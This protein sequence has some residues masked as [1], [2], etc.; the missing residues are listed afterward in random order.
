MAAIKGGAA[1]KFLNTTQKVTQN[2]S[3]RDPYAERYESSTSSSGSGSKGSSSGSA[4]T[5]SSSAMLQAYLAELERQRVQAANDAYNRNVS[6]LNDAYNQRSDLLKNNYNSTLQN[7]ATDYNA[8]KDS[9]NAD[10][11]KAAREAYIN[12]MLSR[13]N[14]AQNMAAQGLSGGASETTMAGL[15]NNY[16]NA[17]NEIQTTA[18]E[19]LGNLENLYTQNKNSALQAY[20]DQLAADALQKAQYMIQFENDRQNLLTQA[21]ESQLSQL[22][23]LDPTYLMSMSG[24]VSDQSAYTPTEQSSPS[25]A[26]KTVNTQQGNSAT[27]VMSSWYA[28][29]ARQLRSAGQSDAQI[30]QDLA[31]QG[32]ANSSILYILNQL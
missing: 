17:R 5:A 8:S 18:N 6:A 19:N 31:N 22:A 26:T 20:N 4:S 9:I 21:Y 29:R 3:Q 32:L 12:S 23:N 14:L 7:L 27:G 24:L 30:A 11:T 16:G 1:N 28:N 10:A 15:Y 13:K 25:N 2:T